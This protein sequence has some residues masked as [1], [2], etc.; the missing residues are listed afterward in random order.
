MSA[1]A[2]TVARALSALRVLAEAPGPVG[3]KTLAGALDLPMS[4][5]HRLLDLLGAEGFVERQAGTRRYVPGTELIRIAGLIAGRTSLPALVR[6]ALERLRDET[7]ET[8]I[9]ALYLP[10]QGAMTYAACA[11]SRHALRYRID[12]FAQSSLVWGAAGLA[13]L[14]WLPEERR[15]EIVAAAGPSPTTGRPVDRASLSDRLALI[16]AR[17]Y[18][19]SEAEKLPDSIGIAAPLAMRPGAP[20]GSIV[21]TIP[22]MRFDRAMTERYGAAVRAAAAGFS[23]AEAA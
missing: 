22:E 15:A 23:G 19:V 12:L 8:A 2:G 21:L 17:G 10:A 16:R 1:P 13:I 4:T 20:A 14:A 5:S 6:P 9:F 11:D 7:G 18:A 3:V